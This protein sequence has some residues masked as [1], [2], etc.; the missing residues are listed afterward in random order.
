MINL[1]S[2]WSVWFSIFQMTSSAQ[3]RKESMQEI[4]WGRIVHKISLVR[5]LRRFRQQTT[6]YHSTKNTFDSV[7][8][9][10][11]ILKA[12]KI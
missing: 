3:R 8:G 12:K 11:I 9:G 1:M 7:V 10:D 4:P 5:R 2:S 6:D